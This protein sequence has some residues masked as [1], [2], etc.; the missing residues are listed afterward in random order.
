MAD[1]SLLLVSLHNCDVVLSSNLLKGI[2]T[3]GKLKE[4]K[5]KWEDSVAYK[6][7]GR[8]FLLIGLSVM[9]F[10]F[11]TLPGPRQLWCSPR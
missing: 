9:F 7:S 5:N 6:R 3:H 10:G 1:S 11:I 4:R 8:L 2:Y